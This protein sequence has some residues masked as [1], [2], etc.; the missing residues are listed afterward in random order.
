[1]KTEEDH[2]SESAQTSAS[3][4]GI[5]IPRELMDALPEDKRKELLERF[6][7]QIVHIRS[8]EHYSGPDVHPDL[9]ARWED[10]LPGSAKEL[11]ELSQ[12]REIQRMSR[13]ARILTIAEKLSAH[14]IN[15]ESK[16][17]KDSADLDRSVVAAIANRERR[18][19]WF[20][21]IAVIGISLGAFYMVRLG[22]D[23]A[24]IAILIFEIVGIAGI[25]VHQLL[26]TRDAESGLRSYR[27]L[28]DPIQTPSLQLSHTP[29]H[30]LA[31]TP[32]SAS[33]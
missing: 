9:A 29:A 28:S 7:Q 30:C 32:A 11:F 19:Q 2:P 5:S 24:G 3:S 12:K 16:D 10:I 22:H 15:T 8:E 27:N 13:Q 17:Q 4:S 23:A 26:S 1:M 6:E 21:F 14:R 20:A 33:Y 31:Y 18:G 25:F